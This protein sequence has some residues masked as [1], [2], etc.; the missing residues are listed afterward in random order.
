LPL[1][2]Q[3]L[4]LAAQMFS[5]RCLKLCLGF[6]QL[7]PQSIALSLKLDEP[8]TRSRQQVGG[9][10]VVITLGV[11]QTGFSKRLHVVLHLNS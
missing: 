7:R 2:N 4:R 11:G 10:M 3:V 6:K 1:P 8:L 9:D 5:F